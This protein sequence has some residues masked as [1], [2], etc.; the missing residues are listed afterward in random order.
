MEKLKGKKIVVTRAL[1]DAKKF[2]N[3]L[4]AKGAVPVVVPCIRFS[5]VDDTGFLDAS[6]LRLSQYNLVVF[7]SATAVRFF[8]QCCLRLDVDFSSGGSFQVVAIGSKTEEALK[9]IGR[10]PDI[11]P[12]QPGDSAV[13]FQELLNAVD[14][15][16]K[17][18]LF[19][20]AKEARYDFVLDLEKAGASVDLAILYETQP[21]PNGSKA[22]KSE[23]RKGHVDWIT[24]ASGSA[25]RHFFSFVDKPRIDTWL[26]EG[27]TKIAAI[28]NVTKGVL[29]DLGYDSSAVA[30]VPT[31]EALIEA[32]EI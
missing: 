27:D 16:G 2:S 11:A 29:K 18:I 21:D 9:K 5:S 32:M 10:I 25:V 30:S 3:L 13:L 19:P 22:L 1:E 23:M 26:Q 20:R 15:D 17:K 24:F 7:T 4:I 12:S 28:G 14:L 8:H 31:F 6:L